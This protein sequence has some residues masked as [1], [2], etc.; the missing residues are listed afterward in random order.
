[1]PC[2]YYSEGEEL[3]IASQSAG[4]YKEELDRTTALLCGLLG[5]LAREKTKTPWGSVPG[6]YVWWRDHQQQ[7]Q[8][9]SLSEARR[10]R[11]QIK[12]AEQLL[13]SASYS[14]SFYTQELAEVENSTSHL[15]NDG[16]PVPKALL[17]RKRSL[18]TLIREGKRTTT[19]IT[20]KLKELHDLHGGS[21]DK[22]R[23][24]K[25]SRGTTGSKEGITGTAKDRGMG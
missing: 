11:E 7:D 16:L 25:G 5:A 17:E 8:K 9:R 22:G 6:L 19:T 1:M 3:A 14:V 4:Q 24:T 21:S 12:H 10:L 23:T 20:K 13:K 2:K 15:L 18:K